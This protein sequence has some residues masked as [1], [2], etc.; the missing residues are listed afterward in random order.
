MTH[1]FWN[2]DTSQLY[3]GDAVNVLA[4]MPDRCVDCVVTSPPYW[5]KRD[6][7]VS[8][9]YGLEATPDDYI[10]NL[11]HVFKEVRRVLIDEGT[12]WLNIGDSYATTTKGSGS[13][14]ASTLENPPS[15]G[16]R[17]ASRPVHSGMPSKNLLGLP[18]R[19]A[20]ALQADGWIIRSAIVWHKPNA[21]PESVTDRLACRYELIF[22][23]AKQQR[24]FFNQAAIRE[25]LRCAPGQR[26][27]VGGRQSAR[28]CIGA[29]VRRR[30]ASQGDPVADTR[31][32]TQR[33]GG[34]VPGDVWSF[35]TRPFHGGH[36]AAF[37]VDIPL[38]AIAAGCPPHGT[39]C[40]PFAGAATTGLAARQLGRGFI[41][42]DISLA[43]MRLAAAR[44]R[45]AAARGDAL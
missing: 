27:V 24:Y 10:D 26:T 44:L 31:Q 40:D 12:L 6:Y 16:A 32:D 20:L 3:L 45:E 4:E 28:G 35:P 22:L 1:P 43:Y 30:G 19:L 29:S 14:A 37:P 13:S 8:G 11:R 36:F 25:P 5:G 15:L 41:G 17:F 39:V 2:D 21:M 42:I 23:L 7:G 9:Q 33:A 38:R 34:R 18:W